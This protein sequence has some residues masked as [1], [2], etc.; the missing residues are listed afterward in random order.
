[1]RLLAAK[2]LAL[3]VCVLSAAQ[4]GCDEPGGTFTTFVVVVHGAGHVTSDD[5]VIDC[6]AGSPIGQGCEVRR[7][8][9]W[10]D[11]A[12]AETFRLR[13]A[14]SENQAFEGWGFDVAA[15]CPGC[16]VG[17]PPMGS[18]DTSGGDASVSIYMN[19]GYDATVTLTATFVPSDT[20]TRPPPLE[21]HRTLP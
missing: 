20:S 14:P 6:H 16:N 3:A 21:L 8:I 18:V 5:G 15:D 2:L 17:D 7:F 19:P 11:P 9:G 1:M 12:S 4:T 13:A 10:T